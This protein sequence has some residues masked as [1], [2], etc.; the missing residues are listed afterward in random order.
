MQGFSLLQKTS[1]DQVPVPLALL[2]RSVLAVLSSFQTF[3]IR[4]HKCESTRLD[5]E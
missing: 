4:F 2:G 1:S 3:S 5:C